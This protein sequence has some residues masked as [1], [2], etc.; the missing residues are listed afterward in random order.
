MRHKRL[1]IGPAGI[2]V[3]PKLKK[4]LNLFTATIYAIGVI[5]GAGIYALIGEGAGIAGNSVWLS[6]VVAAIIASFTGLS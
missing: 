4:E 2:I 6:F 3:M 1:F 5:L